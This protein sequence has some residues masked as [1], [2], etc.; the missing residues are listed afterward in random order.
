[1]EGLDRIEDAIGVEIVAPDLCPRY[2]AS[3]ITGVK[4][5]ESPKWIQ[6]RLLSYGMRPINNIVD[7]TNFVML[8]YGQPLHAFDYE[9]IR[10]KKIIVRRAEDGERII[11]LDDV[12]RTL[13]SDTLVIADTE[14]A[15]A[16]AGVM[17]GA[18]SEVTEFTTS[19]LLEA[20]SFNPASIHYT[21]RT[22][23]M[24][25]EACMRFERGISPELTIPALKRATQ[26]IA[27]LGGGKAVSGIVL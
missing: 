13:S 1:M 6:E 9:F 2:C 24:P 14:R 16:V 11:S 18:N 21:G 4:V 3:L 7:V 17:G 10:G 23:N 12:E 25:S 19:I 26:L 27:E 5:G 20:A 8:E 22:L 15:V